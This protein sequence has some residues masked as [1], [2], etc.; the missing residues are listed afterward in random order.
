MF[1]CCRPSQ[2]QHVECRNQ[3]LLPSLMKQYDPTMKAQLIQSFTELQKKDPKNFQAVTN[4]LRCHYVKPAP[5]ER[6]YTYPQPS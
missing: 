4:F 2:C 1:G 6:T 5:P 3:S